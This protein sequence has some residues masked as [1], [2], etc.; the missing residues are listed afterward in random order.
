MAFVNYLTSTC[1][2]KVVYYGPGLSGK[3][4][5][6]KYIAQKLD[7]TSRGELICL[8]TDASRTYF[9]DLLFVN[10][11]LIGDFNVHFQLL[12]CPGQ[13]FME[14][15]RKSVLSNADGLVFVAD[16]QAPLLDAN[17]QSFEGLRKNLSELKIDID[18]IP[19][20]FQYNKRDLEDLIPIETFNA[21]LNPL[22]RPY[23]EAVAIK[24]LGVFETL[25]GIAGLTIPIVRHQIQPEADDADLDAELDEM[26]EERLNKAMEAVKAEAAAA[27]ARPEAARRP[28]I[29]PACPADID[30]GTLNARSPK[31]EICRDMKKIKLR[32]EKDI[33]NELQKLTREFN[34]K[35]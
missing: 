28:V 10:A 8:E 13:V 14:A 21:L 20:V 24:G 11:G 26:T 34:S 29:E 33:E 35:N 1:A 4:T 15:S 30:A 7:S 27:P 18:S 22:G 9:F 32:S 5:N 31:E 6:I 12:T 19:M 23:F 16:S 25:R 2:I 17:L 3:T